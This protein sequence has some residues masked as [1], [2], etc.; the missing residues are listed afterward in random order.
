VEVARRF[1][2]LPFDHLFFTGSPAVGRSVM[3]AA[4]KNLTPVTL[5]LGGK[6]PALVREGYSLRRA[7]TKIAL[8]KL[9]NGGQ[10][11][12]A[13]D[14]VLV[15]AR[16]RD[17]FVT[18]LC[19]AVAARYP[20]IIDNPDYSSVI[21]ARHYDRLVELVEDARA[22][23]ARVVEVNPAGETATRELRK[24][25]PTLVLDPTPS[26]RVMREEIFGPVLPVV[27]YERLDEALRLIASHDKPLTLYVFDDDSRRTQ[28]LLRHTTSGLVAVNDTLVQFVQEELPIGGVG[29]SGSGNYHGH[30]GFLTLSNHRGVLVQSRLS[31]ARLLDP[32]YR[33]YLE[34]V[35]RWLVHGSL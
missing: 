29:G 12:V 7:A 26:M 4:A 15:P 35:L 31:L 30:S 8:G 32:P 13:V 11:C 16:E 28:E 1:V 2:Q 5:E 17:A 27:T 9:F 19:E 10:S 24:F 6:S 20:R 23:G 34:R 3:E 21:T 18:A 33:S 22:Q 14:Y 25:V